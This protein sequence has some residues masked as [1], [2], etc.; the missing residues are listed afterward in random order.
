[1]GSRS[2]RWGGI[3]WWARRLFERRGRRFR[4]I[5]R[6]NVLNKDFGHVIIIR[7]RS[8]LQDAASKNQ[9]RCCI[10]LKQ[11]FFVFCLLRKNR[12]VAIS[13]S[14]AI[15]FCFSLVLPNIFIFF[16]IFAD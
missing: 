9:N 2:T 10:G 12:C 11:D 16:F 4:G 3:L 1:M 5:R 7:R 14:L 15:F 13:R 6:W 8:Q